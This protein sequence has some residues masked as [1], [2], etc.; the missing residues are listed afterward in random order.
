METT[1]LGLSFS[2][3]MTGLAVFTSNSLIDY[4]LKLHKE[5]W[6]PQKREMIITSLGSCVGNY[7]IT[8]IALSIPDLHQQTRGFRELKEAIEC[9]AESHKI[10]VTLYP[11]RELYQRF[12]SPV[13]RTRNALMKR[14][15]LLFPELS[16][17]YEREQ[18]NRNKYY[19][20]LFEAIAVGAYH[21]FE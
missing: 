11:A 9:F 1:I 2:T 4:S 6:S 14:L 7:T 21:L 8:S 5:I 17:F 18:A 15:V 20:K 19:I 13:K 16:R 10:P 12:G 3:R